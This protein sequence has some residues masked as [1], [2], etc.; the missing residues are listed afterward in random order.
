MMSSLMLEYRIPFGGDEARIC[1][2][3]DSRVVVLPVPLE[4]TTTY[5]KGTKYG[6]EAILRASEN[7]ELYDEELDAEIFRIGI[8]TISPMQLSQVR[9][10]IPHRSARSV[11]QNQKRALRQIERK[12]ET[13]LDDGKFPVI[14]GG[15][16]SITPAA[17]SA[18][19]KKYRK[20]VVVQLDAHAD[21]R[22]SYL[23]SR[24]NHA[25]AMARVLEICPAVQ[26]GI[27]SMCGKEAEWIKG[28][29]KKNWILFASE[30][31]KKGWMEKALSRI[32]GHVYLTIDLDYFDPSIVPSVGT[33]EPG[34]GEWYPTLSFFKKLCKKATV[35]GFDVVELC[36]RRG[37]PASDFLAAKLIYKLLGYIHL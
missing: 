31:Q 1:S 5:V 24:D 26:I 35:V 18:C 4:T 7:M 34:G 29:R 14:L 12:I 19:A 33:P 16:H 36:P 20:L 21:L 28:K 30:M 32:Q 8:S 22:E 13:I 11:G 2:Y 37:E 6:P 23:G 10:T 17:V 9:S 25:C 27:R 15:E 3:G